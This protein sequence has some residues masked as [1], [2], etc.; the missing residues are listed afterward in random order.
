MKWNV[1]IREGY[2]WLR[3]DAETEEER[4][5]MKHLLVPKP[6]N[7]QGNRVNTYHGLA[8]VVEATRAH[9][10]FFRDRELSSISNGTFTVVAYHPLDKKKES[11]VEFAELYF[12]TQR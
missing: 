5:G 10:S 12:V 8:A 1:D 4:K 2:G 7:E 3:L 9:S 6:T 11:D